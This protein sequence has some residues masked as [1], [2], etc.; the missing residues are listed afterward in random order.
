MA[1]AIT[2]CVLVGTVFIALYLYNKFWYK[3]PVI[4]NTI[5]AKVV[6]CILSESRLAKKLRAED[7]PY[8]L[9]DVTYEWEDKTT[10]EIVQAM[11][12]RKYREEIGLVKDMIVERKGNGH[13]ELV[14][15]NVKEPHHIWIYLAIGAVSYAFTGFFYFQERNPEFI[16]NLKN[17]GLLIL[18][19]FGLLIGAMFFF[20][21]FNIFKNLLL[22]EK[23]T[24]KY[25]AEIV[26][27]T[28]AIKKNGK[29]SKTNSILTFKY[30]DNEIETTFEDYTPLRLKKGTKVGD[31]R[32]IYI[33]KKTGELLRLQTV[34]SY[35]KAGATAFTC[36]MSAIAIALVTTIMQTL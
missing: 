15:L 21:K 5:K 32:E 30:I 14:E 31:T 10:G 19:G 23:V 3:A 29:P 28:P 20:E 34:L 2:L 18:V 17:N 24:Q 11:E 35:R 22:D 26:K 8:N 36:G 12:T 1:M 7:C 33:D 27:I 9:Y 13:Q 4:P 25:T 16:T 6:D